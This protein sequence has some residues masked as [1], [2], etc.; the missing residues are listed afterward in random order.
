MIVARGNP[1]S[2]MKPSRKNIVLEVIAKHKISL[3]EFYGKGRTKRI[4]DARIAVFRA[5]AADGAYINEIAKLTKR[6][7]STVRYH[8]FDDVK[9]NKQSYYINKWRNMK[10]NNPALYQE[11]LRKKRKTRRKYTVN[12]EYV[13]KAA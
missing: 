12:R 1:H 10:D 4:V 8:L 13:R 5:M 6:C 3:E 2:R 9:K 7:H 11:T